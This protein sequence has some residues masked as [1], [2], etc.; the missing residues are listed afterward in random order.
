MRLSDSHALC[1]AT[2][3]AIIRLLLI[4]EQLSKEAKDFVEQLLSKKQ[5]QRLGSK[6]LAY[7]EV[8]AEQ[9]KSHIWFAN[10][11][12]SAVERKELQPLYVPETSGSPLHNFPGMMRVQL[13][14]HFQSGKTEFYLHTVI[15][16]CMSRA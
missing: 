10:L 3:N 2:P 5:S 11:D 1:I 8:D 9:V 14:R 4:A 16:M 15:S 6:G 12:F 7:P 13:I